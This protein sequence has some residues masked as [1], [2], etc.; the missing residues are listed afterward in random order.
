MWSKLLA[1]LKSQIG[2]TESPAGSNN[3]KYGKWFGM[4]FVAW[5]AI[6]V[7]WGANTIGML[8]RIGGKRAYTPDMAQ[9]FFNKK[10]WYQGK[11]PKAGYIAF[12]NFGNPN[13]GG[14]WKGIHHVGWVIGV[15]K[16]GRIVTIEGNTSSG[17][18]G[19]Q[20]N[21]GGVFLRYRSPSLIAG[22]GVP[23][24][25]PEV[26]KPPT[27]PT[28]PSFPRKAKMLRNSQLWNPTHGTKR[29]PSPKAGGE[30]MVHQ[31]IADKAG[32]KWASITW[33]GNEGDV[34][35]NDIKYI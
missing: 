19:S 30:V 11:V 27:G 5:C 34:K 8:S 26:A 22:Y 33:G 3:T 10:Q 6:F 21:G 15:L 12:F 4:N 23:K 2:Y 17:S 13:Y 20:S 1:T 32:V 16:D 35:Y 14:R 24:Y 7:C 31:V 18:G 29:S 9:W 25:D 28:G